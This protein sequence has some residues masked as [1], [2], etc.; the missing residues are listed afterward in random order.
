LFDVLAR[1]KIPR[2]KRDRVVLA[3]TQEGEIFW[4]EGLRITEDFKLTDKSGDALQW[5]WNRPDASRDI[6]SSFSP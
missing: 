2:E 5:Q 6:R 3:A 1:N 4:V